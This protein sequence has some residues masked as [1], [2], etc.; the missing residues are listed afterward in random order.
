MDDLNRPA[1]RAIEY[2]IGT[3]ATF[4]RTMLQQIAR[5][6]RAADE[7]TD[8]AAMAA[9][10]GHP[11]APWTTRS[12]DDFGIA[13]LEMWAYLGDILTFYQERIA[14]EAFLRT[15]V[16]ERSTTMLVS[17]IG[18]R[19][20]PGRA[21]V[22]QLAFETERGATV[23]LPAG[24]LV[25]SVPGQDEKP[26]KFETLAD[27]TA[28]ASLNELRPRTL[29]E[30]ALPRG[31]TRAVLAGTGHGISPGDW[32][33]IAGDERRHDPGSE[34]WD[35][36]RVAGVEEDAVAA[37]TT[38]SWT[39]GLGTARRPG[40]AAIEPDANPEFWVFRGQAWPF[41]YN[42]PDYDLF[43][44]SD[45][46]VLAAFTSK[47]DDWNAKHLP[48]DPA[49]PDHLYLDT[50][51]PD[52]VEGG[53]VAL[54]TSTLDT[55]RY[56][57]LAGFDEYVELYPVKGAIATAHANYLLAGRSTRVTLD[58]VS[59]E[60]LEAR[61]EARPHLRPSL[62]TGT[63]RPPEHVE[64]FPMRGTIVL[65]G[66]E[67]IPLADVPLGF[68]PLGAGASVARP[69]EGTT[70]DLDK[71]YPDLRRGRT[72]LVTG[73]LLDAGGQPL[74]PGS[75]SVV[76][77]TVDTDAERTT[78]RVR[79]AM[80]GRYE[81]SSV[82]IYGNVAAASHGETLGTEILGDGD[83]AAEFQSFDL[84]KQPVTYV[85][86]P[87]A[88]G[89]VVSTLQLRVDGVRWTEVSEL[90]GQPADARV[91]VSRRDAS[92]HARVLA[93]D[94]RHGARLPS[95]R[96]NITADYRI[97]LGPEG[98]VGA[99][100]LR[101]LLKKP[102]GLKRVANPAAAAGGASREDLAAVKQTAP[103]TVRTFGRIVS[104]RDFE[105]AA[106][107]YAGIAKARASF[108][109][110]GE[111]RVVDLVVAGDGGTSVDIAASGLLADLDARRDRYQPLVARN[112]ERRP[113]AVRL[114]IAVDEAYL[115]ST[116]R[117]EADAA[118]RA[119]LAFDALELGAAVSLSDVH[120]AVQ[121]VDGVVSVDVDE[122]RF[123]T[124]AAGTCDS[125]LLVAPNQ[126]V[127]V[128]D[129]DDLVVTVRGSSEEAAQ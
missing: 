110:D 128:A 84:K 27:L 91:Y 99:G 12:D 80:T 78:I 41:G 52:I 43:T 65:V 72:L 38:V 64:Y 105:D 73:T 85:P 13:F 7:P 96:N 125:R 106:R 19:P 123:V 29:A 129:P 58:Q 69:V 57:E 53:W 54:V 124:Q 6:R 102:L 45:P 66:S 20:A 15:A 34:R 77:A 46:K 81:R 10:P 109:W 32:V 79:P 61:L 50:V 95:G 89:G 92:Q 115:P 55:A 103:G 82:V 14:N 35:V 1:L 23:S 30:Q 8:A 116:V 127:W 113:V 111:G 31:A 36:R 40:R 67:R 49:R 121:Q 119:L 33:A 44:L 117:R 37:T 104:I 51:Y 97:G 114:S 70:I 11:L 76:V 17:L 5:W 22:A 2:R 9:G 98:N 42:A 74:G 101:T 118:L 94:G 25:Q 120:R 126:L 100:S 71:P 62:G 3:Y 60:Q 47:F 24:M 18:Y 90:Y 122:F 21:A 48:E 59:A 86:E 39:E 68:S 28:Y 87:G 107:E 56:R 4:R 93:G 26:Q 108:A 63:T 112:F 88:P 16:Q 75:E 83:A